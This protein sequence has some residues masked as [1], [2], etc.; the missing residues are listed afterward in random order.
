MLNQLGYLLSANTGYLRPILIIIL[1][2]AILY[3]G[4]YFSTRMRT[5]GIKNFKSGG[6]KVLQGLFIGPNQSLQLVKIYDRYVVLGVTKDRIS[7]IMELSEEDITEAGDGEAEDFNRVLTKFARP[8]KD[9][10]DD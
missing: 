8:K 2:F 1:F 7:L 6:L 10:N 3:G 5:G 9:G 4:Y